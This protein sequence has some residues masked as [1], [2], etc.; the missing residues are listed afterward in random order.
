M[1]TMIM[2][3][4]QCGSITLGA[5][6]NVYKETLPELDRWSASEATNRS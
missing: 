6:G 1:T 3:S 2:L 4:Q 5:G